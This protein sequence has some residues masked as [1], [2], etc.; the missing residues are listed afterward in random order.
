MLSHK[1]IDGVFISAQLTVNYVLN[2]LLSLT[3]RIWATLLSY[4]P[5]GFMTVLVPRICLSHCI[6]ILE[7]AQFVK[8]S[9]PK[10]YSACNPY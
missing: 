10:R 2:R 1:T 4:A 7:Q 6:I 3:T 5:I 8:R 9:F